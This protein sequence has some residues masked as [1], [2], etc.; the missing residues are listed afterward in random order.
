MQVVLARPHG[1]PPVEHLQHARFGL[2]ELGLPI[3]PFWSAILAL[4]VF[5]A[6]MISELV[7]SGLQSVEKGLVE[8]ARALTPHQTGPASAAG[9]LGITICL[10]NLRSGPTSNP[11]TVAEWARESGAMIT[12]DIGHAVSCQRVKEGT[13][14]PLDFVET[15][16]DRLHEVHMYEREENRH[17]PPQD[18]SVLGPIVDRLLDT[19]CRWWTIEL[20]RYDEA[21]A[22]RRLLLGY[23]GR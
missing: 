17:Y 4:T 16:A 21:L 10:E 23:R 11:E 8:A 6:A 3:T 12:L 15:L 13:L 2:P 1:D 9:A 14:T 19:Q 5:E 20:A 7:R 22:T 18:M